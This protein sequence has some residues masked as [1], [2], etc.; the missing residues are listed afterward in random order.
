MKSSS[1]R[2]NSI[3]RSR[4]FPKLGK[5][6]ADTWQHPVSDEIAVSG[7]LKICRIRSVCD[8]VLIKEIEDFRAAGPDKRPDYAVMHRPDALK[9]L[10]RGPSEG[11]QEERLDFVVPCDGQWR[12]PEHRIPQQLSEELI[13]GVTAGLFHTN[14]AFRREGSDVHALNL[15]SETQF[16]CGSRG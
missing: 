13:P 3:V 6:L 16:G 11:S 4:G 10:N 7:R 2:I 9:T 1:F 8:G 5:T 14:G 12:L 15:A